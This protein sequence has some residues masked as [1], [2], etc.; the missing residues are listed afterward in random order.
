MRWDGNVY[1]V[2]TGDIRVANTNSEYAWRGLNNLTE[3]TTIG[4]GR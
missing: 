2:H 4:V 1:L 3:F